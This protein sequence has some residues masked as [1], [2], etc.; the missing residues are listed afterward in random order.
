MEIKDVKTGSVK[1]QVGVVYDEATTTD[2]SSQI[3]DF[4]LLSKSLTLVNEPQPPSVEYFEPGIINANIIVEEKPDL[5]YVE[6]D[7]RVVAE[8]RY[9]IVGLNW[10]VI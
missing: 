2:Y 1:F 9:S 10:P 6:V 3:H 5:D 7:K 8:Q 4:E